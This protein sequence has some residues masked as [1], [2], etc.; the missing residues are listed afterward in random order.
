MVDYNIID[1]A[2]ILKKRNLQVFI[3]A[4]HISDQ[5]DW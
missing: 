5:V 1:Y 4:D 3:D 2:K